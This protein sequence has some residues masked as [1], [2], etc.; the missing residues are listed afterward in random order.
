[1][2]SIP[3]NQSQVFAA[4]DAAGERIKTAL[5]NEAAPLLA[6]LGAD[7]DSN[8]ALGRLLGGMPSNSNGYVGNMT[9]WGV[10]RNGSA[11]V[12]GV[13]LATP[14]DADATM[15]EVRAFIRRLSDG[16]SVHMAADDARTAALVAQWEAAAR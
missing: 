15:A 11:F 9:R 7:T 6:R 2:T 1:M 14:A 3:D 8:R 5:R 12:A 13:C 4:R 10:D 16:V